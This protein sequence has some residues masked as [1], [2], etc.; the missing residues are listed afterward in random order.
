MYFVNGIFGCGFTYIYRGFIFGFDTPVFA[1]R[2]KEGGK[3]G[4]GG[5]IS[6]KLFLSGRLNINLNKAFYTL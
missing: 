5:A 6:G 4:F 1:C 2:G 3:E